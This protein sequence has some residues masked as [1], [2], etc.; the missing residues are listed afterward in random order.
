MNTTQEL[1]QVFGH[2]LNARAIFE[3]KYMV[4]WKVPDDIRAKIPILPAR[5]YINKV[6]IDPFEKVLR[7]LIAKGL[8]KEFKTFDGCYN[9][10]LMRGGNTISRHSWGIAFDFNA[11]WNPLVRGVTPLTWQSLR[12]K[13][14][15]WTEDFLNV[16][17]FNG[18]SC[19]ADWKNSLD[20]M[21]FEYNI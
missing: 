2:P 18:F 3:K 14:V 13:N 8:H 12:A 7:D 1:V 9:P 19:G 11:A 20:G 5:I 15:Q 4:M 10:R 6:I 21:H 16:W 17:R